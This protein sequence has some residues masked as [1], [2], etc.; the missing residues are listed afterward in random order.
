MQVKGFLKRKK[1]KFTL[2]TSKHDI[3]LNTYNVQFSARLSKVI[4]EDFSA[5]LSCDLFLYP[6]SHFGGQIA[7]ASF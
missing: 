3:F 7:V 2:S 5:Y 6:V 4:P 1:E